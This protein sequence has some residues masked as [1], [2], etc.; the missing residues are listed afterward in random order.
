MFVKGI[1]KLDLI[2]FS[3]IDRATVNIED[4]GIWVNSAFIVF[5]SIG[6]SFLSANTTWLLHD[7]LERM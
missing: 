5:G 6:I 4:I 2:T 7:V 1:G 3:N